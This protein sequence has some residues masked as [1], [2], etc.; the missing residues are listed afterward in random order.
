MNLLKKIYLKYRDILY[1]IKFSIVK[2]KRNIYMKKYQFITENSNI[3][4]N[5]NLKDNLILKE[6]HNFRIPTL[7][8]MSYCNNPIITSSMVNDKKDTVGVADPIILEEDGVYYCFFELCTG[9]ISTS[10]LGYAYSY[11][12]INWNYG[13]KLKGFE[14]RCAFPNL[15]EYNNEW[16]MIPDTSSS[17]DVYKAVE[18]P[19]RWIK[20]N[21]L[22]DGEFADTDIVELDG[23]W[24]MFTLNI[25]EKNNSISIY[26]NNTGEWNNSSWIEH[27]KSP[28]I[29][30]HN[31]RLG[32]KIIKNSNNTLILPVQGTV[33][34]QYGEKLDFYQISNLSL[35][36]ITVSNKVDGLTG[37]HGNEWT[38]LGIHQIDMLTFQNGNLYVVDGLL[39]P[40][41]NY[42]IGIYTDGDPFIFYNSGIQNRVFEKEIWTKV[43]FK[44]IYDNNFMFDEDSI[45]VNYSGFYKLN[46]Q[47]DTAKF[48][49]IL[50]EKI[51]YESLGS[52]GYKILNLSEGDTLYIEIYTNKNEI[53]NNTEISF[54]EL[55]KIY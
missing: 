30:K 3:I 18:F 11:N 2:S 4:N 52:N 8:P 47:I 29:E 19:Q 50:N 42:S 10:E 15:F 21:K 37:L 14:S 31:S 40:N 43:K 17:I 24:Y 53:N 41:E 36:S 46:A 26:Y 48:R 38:N 51:I 12:G 45:K 44:K 32:G 34:G 16:Y 6:K 35:K 5:K 9:R 55:Q 23:I 1:K 33:S 28:I 13:S 49:V 20:V 22:I 27:P 25:K 7:K 39:D 54:I